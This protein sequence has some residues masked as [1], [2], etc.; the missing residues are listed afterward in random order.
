MTGASPAPSRDERRSPFQGLVPYGEA[1]AD[2]FFGRREWTEIIIDNLRAYRLSIL[3]GASGVGKSSV[4]NAGVIRSSGCWRRRTWPRVGAQSS[5]LCR[6]R[7]GAASGRSRPEGRSG[8][9]SSA[10][11]PLS[12]CARRPVGSRTSSPS[13][14][15]GSAARC[16]SSSTS[17]RTTSSTTRTMEA[18][19]P[20]RRSCR[21]RCDGGGRRPTS[22][23]RFAKTRSRGSTASRPASRASSRTCSA[24]T[25]STGRPR[26]RRSNGRSSSGTTCAREAVEIEPALVDAVLDQ[27]ETGKV[28]LGG[29]GRRRRSRRSTD[30]GEGRIEAP[31]LQLVLSRLWAGGAVARPRA[32]SACRR[33]TPRWRRADRAHPPRRDDGRAPA[34][35]SRMSWPEPSA[36][37]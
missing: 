33:S 6:S 31:Y 25:T 23:S 9:P 35:A 1:D 32:F 15:R 5:S 11:P 18:R 24:S 22:S 19:T 34:H 17:S 36:T 20:S 29:G 2:W 26:G 13:G 28:Q 27:V 21:S 12:P 8:R 30:G 3:Y 10:L 16:W 4:L 14:R 7:R 37:S